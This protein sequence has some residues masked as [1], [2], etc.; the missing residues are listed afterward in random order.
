MKPAPRLL[1]GLAAS[2]AVLALV[3]CSV[4]P[5]S[6]QLTVYSLPAAYPAQAAAPLAPARTVRVAAP[7]SGRMIDSSRILVTPSHNRLS[8]YEGARWSDPVPELLRDRLVQGLLRDGRLQ[9]VSARSGLP[10]DLELSGI[11]S[12]FQVRYE[13]QGPVARI[14]Y[15]ARLLRGDTRQT[16]AARTFEAARP[17]QGTQAAAAV[18]ALGLATDELAQ[19]LIDWIAAQASQGL[20][21]AGMPPPRR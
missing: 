13:S 7:E 11:L 17:L 1:R 19:A 3:A 4:L 21:Q 8:A 12:E 18:Q 15:D 6:R 9:A 16:L 5:E 20:P 10:A 2:T 14:R